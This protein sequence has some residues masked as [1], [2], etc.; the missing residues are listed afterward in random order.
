MRIELP[1]FRKIYGLNLISIAEVGDTS[2][3]K[4]TT[5][6][7]SK[8]THPSTGYIGSFNLIT[9]RKT[10]VCDQVACTLNRNI[11]HR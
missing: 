5:I 1:K 2:L 11:Y 4:P 3:E 6:D 7:W 10:Y 9:H 8:E